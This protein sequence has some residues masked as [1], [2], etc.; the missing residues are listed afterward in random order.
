MLD[1]SNWDIQ[2]SNHPADQGDLLKVFFSKNSECGLEEIEKL[3]YDG[4]NSV[5]MTG[6]AR[7]AKSLTKKRLGDNN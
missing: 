7:A 3:D 6:T 1:D 2:I 5:K 4:E